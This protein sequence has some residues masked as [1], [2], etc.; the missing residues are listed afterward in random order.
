MSVESNA[1]GQEWI[2]AP[3]FMC[4]NQCGLRVCVEEGKVTQIKGWSGH[5]RSK[6]GLCVKA[7][8]IPEYIYHK[9]RLKYP[10]KKNRGKWERITWDEALTT[11]AGKWLEAKQTYGPASCGVIIGEPACLTMETGW[12]LGWRLCDV[13]GTPTRLEA[14]DLCGSSTWLA[15]LA[16][17]GM[18]VEPDLQNSDCV[19][20]WATNPHASDP[21]G[22]VMQIQAAQKKG[23][24]IIVIDPRR[25]P[26]AKRA[27]LHIRPWPGTDGFLA[28]AMINILIGEKIYNEEFVR[29]HTNGFEQL[30]EHVK[31]FTP[32]A[33]ERVTGVPAED[34]R[35][36]TRIFAGSA[37]ACIR[38]Y[39]R[40]G[41]MPDGFQNYRSLAILSA[42][43]GNIDL[44][45]G[46]RLFGF[47]KFTATKSV[48][49]PEMLE[50]PK[51]L[52][53]EKYPLY[54]RLLSAFKDGQMINWGD[55]VL[56]EPKQLRNLIVVGTN[57]AVTWP[58]TPKLR[59]ALANLDFL[60]SMDVGI[61]PTNENADII[62]PATTAFERLNFSTYHGEFIGRKLIPAYGEAKSEGEF[63]CELARKM[64]YEEHFPWKSDEE[65]FNHFFEPH[66]LQGLLAVNP[67]GYLN[68]NLLPG[69]QRYRTEGFP[70]ASGKVELYS[71]MLKQ[72]GYDPLPTY[73]GPTVNPISTPEVFKAYP[74]HLNTGH[75]EV[76]WWHSMFRHVEGLRRRVPHPTAEIHPETAARYGVRDGEPMV[77][78][79]TIGTVEIV[80]RV[81]E[82][83]IQ[84]MVSIPHGWWEPHYNALTDDVHLDKVTGFPEYTGLL[85]RVRPVKAG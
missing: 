31:S 74:L 9:D 54:S 41:W 20:I 38:T 15:Q 85:C 65:T 77:V 71:E 35:N 44:T 13:F 47:A 58:N 43:T 84:G 34:I 39:F 23:A 18:L 53:A 33:A 21:V 79:S 32:Q 1:A 55:L 16:T 4:T 69:E 80:A 2:T 82:D 73:T 11:I 72:M 66:T 46:E 8:H 19:V 10:M 37:S 57:P 51:W 6:G 24:K 50:G 76:E 42:L 30:A 28:L 29:N 78:E 12:F 68:D 14:L 49:M 56:N 40:L 75:R 17:Y 67:D 27:D 48:R 64:G 63:W 3:C 26:F 70:T 59:K 61:T 5:P 36:L 45:G 60:V 81:T 25:T 83:I 22:G 52:G 7:R 62:L